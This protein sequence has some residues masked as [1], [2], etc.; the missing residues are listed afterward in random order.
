M[1]YVN[2]VKENY[3]L[4]YAIGCNSYANDYNLAKNTCVKLKMIYYLYIKVTVKK[5]N[6]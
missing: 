2:N 1:E 4:Y 5:E 3:V 6:R